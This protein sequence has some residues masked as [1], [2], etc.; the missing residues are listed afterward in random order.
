MRAYFGAH[1]NTTSDF[2]GSPQ[3]IAERLQPFVDNGL[4]M[5]VIR[6]VEQDL[7]K[8][9]EL[10]REAMSLVQPAARASV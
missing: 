7:P 1:T 2:F 6:F 8:Q 10:M 9:A 3:E 4:T 5:L